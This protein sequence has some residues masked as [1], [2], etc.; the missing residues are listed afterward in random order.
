MWKGLCRPCGVLAVIMLLSA[1]RLSAQSTLVLETN[2]PSLD[3][4]QLNTPN[5]RVLYP[6][7][8]EQQ[9][10]R[11][12]NTLETIR[13]PE[14]RTMGTAPRKISVI[15]QNQSSVSNG[16][17]A[18]APR[19]SEFYTMPTQNYNF[20]GTNDWLDA[21]SVHEYRHM[22][23]FQRSITGF[24]KA[25]SFVFGQQFTAAM[26]FAA[27]PQWFW[28]GDA[29]ATETAFTGSGRGRIPQF[30]LLFRTNATNGRTFNYHKQYL[31][32][33]KHNIPDHYVL[34]YNMVTHL[35]KK[36][37]DPMI[38]EKVVGRSWKVPFIPFAF[39]N[40]LK[41]ETGMHVTELY[42]DMAA[43]RQQDYDNAVANLAFTPF[44][45]LTRREGSAY[46]DYQYPQPLS[47]GS[48]LVMKSGIG[49]IDQ[50]VKLSPGGGEA[51]VF[52]QG[53]VNEGAMLSVN[54]DRVVWNEYRFD[55][56]WRVKSYSVVMGYDVQAKVKK[57]VTSHSRFS[58]AALAPDGIRIATVETS[59]DYAVR[60]VMLSYASG[61]LFKKFEN[62][63]NDLLA[64]PRWT[65]DGKSILI[66]R[67]GRGGK[68]IS[69]VDAETGAI[70]DLLPRSLENVGHPVS[71][72]NYVLFNSP[73][74]GIDNIHAVNLK[75]SKRFRVTTSRY[76]AYNPAVSPDG[77]KLY[78]NEQTRDG[79]DV[80]FTALDTAAWRPYEGD[81]PTSNLNYEHLVEQEAHPELLKEV[82]S[83]TYSPKR[84]HKGAGMINPHSWG[85]Y[86]TGTLTRLNIGIASQDILSTTRIFAGYEYDLQ[87]RTGQ[88]NAG[89]S[90]QGLYPI[91]D[92]QVIRADRKINEGSVGTEVI[93][94]TDTALQVQDLRFTWKETSIEGGLRIPLLTTSSRFL[95]SVQVANYVGY[96]RVTD[97]SNSISGD[98][99][100]VNRRVVNGDVTSVYT[101]FNYPANGN[102]YYN[103][104]SIEAYRL[105]KRSRRDIN[106]KWGQ[107]LLVN[108][109]NTPYGGDYSGYQFSAYGTAYFPGLFKHH[110]I[111]GY[112]AYQK[113]D[114]Q[115]QLYYT[116]TTRSEV[117]D[118]MS[119]QFRNQIP[120]PRGQSVSRFINMYSA[121]VNYTLPLWYPDIAIGPI[122]NLQRFRGNV[123]FDY[124][125]GES[126]LPN[127][128][129][130]QKYA[131]VGGELRLDF[132]VMRFLPQFSVGLRYSYGLYPAATK[133]N[134]FEVFIGGYSF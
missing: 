79:L 35:R 53:I 80:V 36:T 121:S 107:F 128:T 50:L 125:E 14:A 75:T 33:Y 122:I 37:G 108:I 86:F 30:D 119:Y 46:T 101:Y 9:A 72:R 59:E 26:A 45:I 89:I 66:L 71:W 22:A 112:L 81:A 47:D 116:D 97:F 23:Q 129:L 126:I 91:L 27:A 60:L 99:R 48:V 49:D 77:L 25:F 104:F 20:L 63:G 2:A 114:V 131:S 123:F 95:G 4:Y 21:L 90:Y 106:S 83:T 134:L 65:E 38:W 132:N 133:A 19:R 82:T 44:E 93:N 120:L 92:L 57:Q 10:Q 54:Q 31:R 43:Q 103:H 62:P 118:N 15:L 98:T 76:G 124:A 110:S 58:G 56:R 12:A 7:G 105:L 11:V 6:K 69:M 102:L 100:V 96:T 13:D 17:V 88:W 55:P 51:K 34:G 1:Q 84:Y 130:F 109:Y 117:A 18:M 8:F 52:V 87:E 41:R 74:G 115:Q 61:S 73:A 5:F 113:S 29:V 16:F 70:R 78:Y 28:E 94:G 67:T 3:W 32:S 85:P 40:A 127:R 111:W 42:R 68:T 24:N 64:M 39:S